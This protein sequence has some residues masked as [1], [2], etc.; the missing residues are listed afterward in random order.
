MV[1]VILRFRV[2]NGMEEEVRAAF[3]N[4]PRLVE[5]VEGFL[6]MEVFTDVD[7]SSTFD[8]L[9]RWTDMNAYIVWHSSDAHRLSH[10]GIP[11]GLKVTPGLT[12]V[13]RLQKLPSA[14]GDVCLE[15]LVAD[16]ILPLTH[17][18]ADS[19]SLH[20]VVADRDGVIRFYNR[21][22]ARSLK[23]PEERFGGS[24]WRLLT[25]ASA[26]SLRA[27]IARPRGD[28]RERYLQN[29]VDADQSPL[30]LECLVAV[31][32]D[33]ILLLGEIPRRANDF[34]ASELLQLNNELAVLSRENARKSKDLEFA[35][36]ELA[37]TLEDL[38]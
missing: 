20:L 16:S 31:R 3:S 4:R 32:P 2:R 13:R 9:T 28:G 15:G 29:F 8:L 10:G 14:D 25:Q 19:A 22:F 27:Q 5:Q 38:K 1:V 33:D 17:L 6:G 35:R 37:K 30:T 34:L 18:L 12:E 21:A 7:D 23:M 11:A 36:A 24:L 26:D